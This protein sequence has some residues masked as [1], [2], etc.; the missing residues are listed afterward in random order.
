MSQSMSDRRT[1]YLIKL[2]QRSPLALVGW[3]LVAIPSQAVTSATSS[4]ELGQPSQSPIILAQ[5]IAPAADGTGVCAVRRCDLP[6]GRAGQ[7]DQC[8]ALWAAP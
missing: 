5:A 7:D 6:A 3:C 8:G 1:V 2:L 4:S